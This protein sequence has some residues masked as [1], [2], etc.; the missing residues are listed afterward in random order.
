MLSVFGFLLATIIIFFIEFPS[1][2][3]NR[4]IKECWLFSMLLLFAFTLNSAISLH[5]TLPNP[6][7]WIAFLYKPLSDFLH[8]N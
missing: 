3:K 8:I 1:L 2:W 4:Q 6:L 5:F 7:D